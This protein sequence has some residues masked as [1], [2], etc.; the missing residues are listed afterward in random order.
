MSNEQTPWHDP[1]P[2]PSSG[3]ATLFLGFLGVIMLLPGLCAIIGVYQNPKILLS[4]SPDASM[5]WTF[6]AI[7]AGGVALISWLARPKR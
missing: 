6:L 3:C 7:G 2:R 5:A 4:S 1:K